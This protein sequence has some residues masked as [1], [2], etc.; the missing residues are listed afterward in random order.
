MNSG[1]AGN[2]KKWINTAVA[3]ASVILA[4]VLWAFFGKLGDWLELEA[5]IPHFIVIAQLLA[6]G[7]GFA[8]FMLVISHP[9]SSLFLQEVFVEL[10][11]VVWPNPQENVRHTLGIVIGV[12]IVGFFLALFD[13]GISRL[14]NLIYN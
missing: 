6:A 14:L 3:T 10:T 5:K 8:V 11:K 2:E 12:T 4:Y 9:K 7:L 1:I 13:F